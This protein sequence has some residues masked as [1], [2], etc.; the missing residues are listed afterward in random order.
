MMMSPEEVSAH[1]NLAD[2]RYRF[3]RWARPIVPVVFGA[4]DATLGV[5]KGALEAVVALAGHRMGETDPDLGAN[6]MVFFLRD[7][8]ELPQVPGLDGIVPDLPALWVRLR[9]EDAGQYRLF[10][11]EPDGAIK[12]AFVFVRVAGPLAEMPAEDL[13]LNEAVRVILLW[14]Q[15]AFAGTSPLAVAAGGHVVLR[16][17]I[18]ALI[19]AAY[20]PVL[21]A[22]TDQPC[23][24]LRLA[25]RVGN[26]LTEQGT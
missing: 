7:W 20:D 18:A 12:A 9:D 13:A 11:F 23:H 8:A 22:A 21:P 15:T 19:R 25:A 16:P 5:V 14:S 24:A 3:A 17:Q 2:G 1:F 4:Q 10:R 6:L 26:F